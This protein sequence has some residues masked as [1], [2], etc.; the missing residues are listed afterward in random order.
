[1]KLNFGKTVLRINISF[2]AAVT[3]T[4]IIDE[5]GL[6]AA[7]LFC[8]VIHELG[9]IICLYILG[10]KPGVIELSFYG[11]RLERN[12]DCLNFVENI[13]VYLSGSAANLILSSVLFFIGKSSGIKT[14]AVVSLC[15]GIFN[16]LPCQPLD[17]G[18]LLELILSGFTDEEKCRKICFFVSAA[19]VLP[20]L[21]CGFL[22]LLRNGN[23]TLLAVSGYL[24]I[25]TFL[26]NKGRFF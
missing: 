20:L 2:A 9:H 22:L 10:E 4:L 11:V 14:A 24:A 21:I 1:M 19:M 7:A 23:T 5:S 13:A 12:A 8:C 17:G 6:C 15:V 25:M 18:N 26:N 3:L 16:M